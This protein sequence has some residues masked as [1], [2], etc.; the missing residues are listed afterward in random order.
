M[1][2]PVD[3]VIHLLNN[4]GQIYNIFSE[5][6]KDNCGGVGDDDEKVMM[7]MIMPKIAISFIFLFLFFVFLGVI[8]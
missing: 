4:R 5:N 1:I 2:Y 7:M 3:S 8:N 6:N